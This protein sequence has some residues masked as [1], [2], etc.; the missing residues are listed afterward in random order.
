MV[1]T[2]AFTIAARAPRTILAPA[3]AIELAAALVEARTN[4][5]S[6]VPWGAGTRQHI[7]APPARYDLVLHTARLN[8]LVE[9]SPA[10]LVLTVEAGATLGAVQARL[11]EHGQWLPW[12]PP[13]AANATIGGLLATAATG[14]ARLGYGA[15]RDWTLSLRVALGDGRLVKSGAR[16][17]KNVAGYD[18]HKLHIGALGTLG[19]I[20]EA[21][22]KLAPL[23]ACRRTLLISFIDRRRAYDAVARL[24]ATPL[25]PVSLVLLNPAA[26]HM[27]APL[28]EFTQRQPRHTTLAIRFAGPAAAVAR[29]VRETVRRSAELDARCIDLDERDDTPIWQAVSDFAAAAHENSV[30]LRSGVRPAAFQQQLT[31]LE[32]VA[33]EYGWPVAHLAYAGTGLA[34]THWWPAQHD[35]APRLPAALA[36]ARAELAGDQP[37]A[38]ARESYLVVEAAS[39]AQY[40]LTAGDRWGPAPPALHLM[41]MLKSQWDP[42]QLLNPGRYLV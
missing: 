1:T 28:Q 27:I 19:V 32:Q 3:D 20:V 16:V 35:A 24:R 26:E 21:T 41:Q 17:V 13:A 11:A 38:T 12:D 4:G 10:D 8:R 34:F 18:A 23:P 31:A 33:R 14:P 29:Q 9:Y 42:A 15:P 30:L 2:D 37:A 39:P 7:G 5:L 22:F 40:A 25:S 6:V 36:A